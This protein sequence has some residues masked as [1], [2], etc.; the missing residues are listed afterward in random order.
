MSESTM[1]AAGHAMEYTAVA[2]LNAGDFVQL[3]GGR[4]GQ[5]VLAVAA[6]E[7][8]SVET[9]GIVTATKATSMA[10]LPGIRAY[11]DVANSRVTYDRSITGAFYIGV[12]TEDAAESD[13]TCK[14]RLNELP[15]RRISWGEGPWDCVAVRTAGQVV[16]NQALGLSGTD[17]GGVNTR[18]TF[19]ATAEAQKVDALSRR[20]FRLADKAIMGW[21]GAIYDIGDNAALDINIGVANGTH[22]TDADSITESA[23]IHL[24]GTA[25]DIKAES[26]DGTTE[27]S[28]T[29]TTI[30][31]VDDTSFEIWWDLRDTSNCKLYINGARVLSG[32]T[33]KLNAATGPMKVL[34]PHMEKTS[35]DTTAD[36]RTEDAWV[37]C[38]VE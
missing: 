16:P 27:V 23:F 30:D 31:A 36:V 37:T 2:A 19:S 12:V 9:C 33:F 20:V 13:T 8:A 34:A 24:D 14:V 15:K 22:A 17:P 1:Y 25:L 3:P 4:V 21:R 28:A 11:W 6:G 38:Q 18:F 10:L 35:D 32:T 5:V 29:D 7:V 26:D